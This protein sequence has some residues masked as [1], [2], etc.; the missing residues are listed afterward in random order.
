MS[1]VSYN[2]EIQ[3]GLNND[4]RTNTKSILRLKSF[5]PD[6]DNKVLV[7]RWEKLTYDVSGENVLMREDLT[8]KADASS[9]VIPGNQYRILTIEQLR[10]EFNTPAT[11]DEEGN[12]LTPEIDNTPEYFSEYDFWWYVMNTQPRPIGPTL[13]AYG[14]EFAKRNNLL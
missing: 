9:V 8:Q 14:R 11:Y 7:I 1:K 6:C 4:P 2:T 5:T 3:I 12:V 10:Q 13:E